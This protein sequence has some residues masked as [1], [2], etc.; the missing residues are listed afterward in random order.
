MTDLETAMEELLEQIEAERPQDSAEGQEDED[1]ESEEVQARID[2]RNRLANAK[3]S[4]REILICTQD[5]GD[6]KLQIA[7]NV[8]DN[9]ENKA[10]QLE[11]DKKNLG[12]LLKLRP[13]GKILFL[14]RQT[15]SSL[16]NGRNY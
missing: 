7:Q 11:L 8:Q 5:L 16:S 1:M 3:K 9:I 12:E 15:L 13:R 4:V 10:R 2:R 6:E 14:L